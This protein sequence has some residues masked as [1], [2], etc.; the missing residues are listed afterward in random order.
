MQMTLRKAACLQ[1]REVSLLHLQCMWCVKGSNGRPQHWQR[2]QVLRGVHSAAA[3][4]AKPALLCH[5]C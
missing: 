1:I 5:F 2:S 3:M 4:R